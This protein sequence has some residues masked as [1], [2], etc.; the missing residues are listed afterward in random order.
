MFTKEL[1]GIL[2]LFLIFAL[3]LV[4]SYID[5]EIY[6]DNFEIKVRNEEGDYHKKMYKM[7]L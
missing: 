5:G 3:V 1:L 7:W 4:K 6:F 2:F